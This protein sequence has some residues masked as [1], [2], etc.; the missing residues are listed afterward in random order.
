[1]EIVLS[2][3]MEIVLSALELKN[4]FHYCINTLIGWVHQSISINAHIPLFLLKAGI[5]FSPR[6]WNNAFKGN[7]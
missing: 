5:P 1:M 7:S 2:P 4:T 3:L 6:N